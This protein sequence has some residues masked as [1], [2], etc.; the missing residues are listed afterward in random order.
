[1]LNSHMI[2]IAI[3]LLHIKGLFVGKNTAQNRSIEMTKRLNKETPFEVTHATP[4]TLKLICALVTVE[5]GVFTGIKVKVVKIGIAKLASRSDMAMLTT[6]ML[7]VVLILLVTFLYT[8]AMS[9]ELPMIQ[10]GKTK[11]SNALNIEIDSLEKGKIS[12]SSEHFPC[13]LEFIPPF[14]PLFLLMYFEKL[15]IF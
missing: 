4:I 12:I 8:T 6:N 10:A 5:F 3:V 15:M 9:R 14:V 11:T 7:V 1:M 2:V 13:P